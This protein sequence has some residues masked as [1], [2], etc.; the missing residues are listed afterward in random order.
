MWRSYLQGPHH[1]AEKSST[2]CDV[3]E[4]GGQSI[5]GSEQPGSEQM[6]SDGQK[7]R[8]RGGPAFVMILTHEGV[9]RD[10]GLDLVLVL[11]LR[12]DLARAV[13]PTVVTQLSVRGYSCRSSQLYI[14]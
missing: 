5:R 1:V 13:L 11:D 4:A 3:G 10:D 12:D 9:R 7:Q 14:L 8:V 2:V 6:L